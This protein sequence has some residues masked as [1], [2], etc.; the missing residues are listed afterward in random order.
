M[1]ELV[2]RLRRVRAQFGRSRF[3]NRGRCVLFRVFV[4][5]TTAAAMN[6]SVLA[7]LRQTCRSL[8]SVRELTHPL[9]QCQTS[10]KASK[11][12]PKIR[13]SQ[14]PSRNVSGDG[15]PGRCHLP[16]KRQA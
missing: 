11:Q 9:R 14:N 3:R 2:A 10:H 15:S 5:A 8:A 4:T 16:L 1:S 6:V 13:V 12:V 7:T